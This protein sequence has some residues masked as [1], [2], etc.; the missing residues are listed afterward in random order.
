MLLNITG[1]LAPVYTNETGVDAIFLTKRKITSRVMVAEDIA[2]RGIWCAYP[3]EKGV[4]Y[5]IR[6][7]PV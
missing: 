5:S 6:V 3:P 1:A 4:L 2:G 7:Q